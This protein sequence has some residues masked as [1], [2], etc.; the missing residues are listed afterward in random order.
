MSD[1]NDARI[2]MAEQVFDAVVDLPQEERAA[3]LAVCCGGDIELRTFVERLLEIDDQTTAEVDRQ[4]PFTAARGPQPPF[5][6]GRFHV[7]RTLGEGGMGTVYEAEQDQP[8]RTVALKLMKRGIASRSAL[9]RFEHE[10]QILARLHHPGIAQVYDADVYEDG[11]SD[12]GRGGI[13]YF[14]MEYIPSAKPIT[15]FARMKNLSTRQRL[16]LFITVCDAVQHGHQ[17]GI[18]HRDLKPGNILVDGDGLI[19]VIDFGVARA[20]DADVAMTTMQ[21]DVGQLI[22]TLQYMSPEQCDADP[23]D[24]DMR[25]D[26]YALGVVLYE[27]LT[28][29][30]P[31]DVTNA[32]I[33]D[34]TRMIREHTPARPSSFNR[35]LRGDLE[36]IVLK[37]LEKDRQRRYQS[38]ADL[39]EDIRRYLTDRPIMARPP[40]AMYQFRTFARRNKA[41]VGGTAATFIAL[42]AGLIGVSAMYVQAEHLRAEAEERARETEK[43][44]TFQAEMF[45][46]L[47]AELMGVRLR[48]DVLDEARQA[49]QRSGADEHEIADRSTE[50]ERLVAGTNFTNAAV[51]SIDRNILA[52]ALEAIA[53]EFDDVPLVQAALFQTVAN[54]YRELGLFDAA[55]A[56]QEQALEIR[57]REFGDEH[58]DTLQ[59]MRMMAVLLQAQGA[60]AEVEF[61]L[62][63]VLDARRVILGNDHPH[64]IDSI[65]DMCNNYWAQGRIDE[66]EPYCREVLDRRRRVLGDEHLD[67]INS[68]SAM[69]ELLYSQ[70]QFAEAELHSRMAV[71]G[72]RRVMN[73]E[74]TD[75]AH[76]VHI[77]GFQLRQRGKLG[78]AEQFLRE[79]VEMSRRLYGDVH[80]RTLHTINNFG[81][82]LLMQENFAE[83]E[84]YFREAM[85]GNL[86][87]HGE[88]H[89][90]TVIPMHHLGRVLRN[91]GRLEEAERIGA[92]AVEI[93]MHAFPADQWHTAAFLSQYGQTLTAMNRFDQAQ[94]RLLEAHA[95]FDSSFGEQHER[96]IGVIEHLVDLYDAWHEHDPDAA[97]DVQ[98]TEWRALIPKE[99]ETE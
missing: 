30:L 48:E 36:T 85:E 96:T 25:S 47:D 11:A 92:Q 77:L 74:H 4:V 18:I 9:R 56:P 99:D 49:W 34:A 59:S 33:Y 53:M 20:T 79:A 50:L 19:K 68:M 17:K 43:V 35:A 82:L 15:E 38:A 98:A 64:T 2:G 52:T 31:Y 86:L 94:E 12:P 21:T 71:A 5:Q 16:D 13:P 23:H 78:E 24:L 60:Y 8:K 72:Y 90:Y 58:L 41:L 14:V 63:K 22:G 91:L 73:D 6:I 83:A 70:R 44:A 89:L 37:A 7:R 65:D 1:H 66:A 54:T 76:A 51:R 57:L 10:A 95:I 87:I 55:T 26:V 40:S 28:D 93:A 42:I 80:P 27:L 61:S 75:V 84:R 67:T 3:A 29:Q 62:R 88:E 39:A 81:G 69:S 32:R 97:H 46:S 45:T